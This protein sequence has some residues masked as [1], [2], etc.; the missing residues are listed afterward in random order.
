MKSNSFVVNT[1]LTIQNS[2]T[3]NPFNDA[4]QQQI[5]EL[6]NQKTHKLSINISK[7]DYH[8]CKNIQV[9][10]LNKNNESPNKKQPKQAN[11]CKKNIPETQKRS[12]DKQ[13]DE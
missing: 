12:K 7:N 8:D 4:S 13:N 1:S 2:Q 9:C 3:T 5:I 6:K 11:F 10:F